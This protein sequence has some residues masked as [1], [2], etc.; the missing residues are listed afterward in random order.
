MEILI[1]KK[2]YNSKAKMRIQKPNNKNDL[3]LL[4]NYLFSHSSALFYL[5]FSF[6][7]MQIFLIIISN[8][9]IPYVKYQKS[10]TCLSSS[11]CSSSL[12]IA[13]YS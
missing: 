3:T 13:T 4:F 9:F 2:L 5:I 8:I 1:L 11:N 12:S 10:Y 6:T 7:Y